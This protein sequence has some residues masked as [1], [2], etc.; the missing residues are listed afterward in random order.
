MAVEVQETEKIRL[1]E[2]EQLT[3]NVVNALN[4]PM[5]GFPSSGIGG[6]LSTFKRVGVEYS[7]DDVTQVLNGLS[8]QGLVD[9][10]VDNFGYRYYEITELGRRHV[11]EEFPYSVKGVTIQMNRTR[12]LLGAED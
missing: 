2:R 11:T 7:E 10:E 5:Q 8:G 4:Y 6:I 1:S 9:L 12:W 3:L